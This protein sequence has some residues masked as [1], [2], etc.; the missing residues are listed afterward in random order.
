[1]DST[2]EGRFSYGR[3][4]G[5]GRLLA[6]RLKAISHGV[7]ERMRVVN[8]LNLLSEVS[9]LSAVLSAL[10]VIDKLSWTKATTQ[11]MLESELKGD[12]NNGPERP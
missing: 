9:P 4:S 5:Q 8:F 6:M 12:N 10:R 1:M 2:T 11:I 3:H 7:S